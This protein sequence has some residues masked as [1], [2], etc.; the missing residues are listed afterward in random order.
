[1]VQYRVLTIALCVALCACV[2]PAPLKIGFIGGLSSQNLDNGQSG[3]KGVKLAIDQ[4]NRAGGINNRSIELI[5]R[6]DAQNPETA[7]A[8]ARDLAQQGVVAVIGPF[9]SSMAAAIVPV[10]ERKKIPIVSPTITAME[11]YGKDD[12]LIRINRTTQDNAS[13]YAAMLMRRGQPR[14]AV[15]YDLRNR[16]FTESWLNEFRK[17]SEQ[18]GNRILAE[19]DYVSNE[20]TDF[21]EIAKRLLA[22]KP[23]TLL[24]ISGAHDVARLA[25]EARLRAPK[26]PLVAAEWAATD[27]LLQLGGAVVEGL[28]IVQN[29]NQDDDSQ[30]FRA[31]R[32]AHFQR[33]QAHPSYSAVSAYD[34][35]TVVIAALKKQSSG[36]SLKAALLAGNPYP[37]LQQ[38]IVFDANG[39]TS[40]KIYFA[41]I[42]SGKYQQIHW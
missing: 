3:L 42:R 22:S 40:R 25:R 37:G 35:A 10:L 16:M 13:D 20:E 8:A 18:F 28:L 6:D 7:A 14:V 31:F 38:E 24:F 34:A 5:I 26:I 19:V 36:Q 21:P 32:D 30:R 15:A 29:Y 1:M 2:K 9:T 11:F 4:A 27:G 17:A 39:D 33:F 23:D 41:E 12:C